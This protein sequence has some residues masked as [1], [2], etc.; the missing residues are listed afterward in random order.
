M[1]KFKSNVANLNHIY[2]S[3]WLI[4]YY[5]AWSY[6]K[7]QS[8]LREYENFRRG[9][10]PFDDQSINHFKDGVFEFWSWATL[11][12]KELAFVAQ[13]IFGICINA[14]LLQASI[15]YQHQLDDKELCNSE[16]ESE[17]EL[18]SDIEELSSDIE[19]QPSNKK[20]CEELKGLKN[21]EDLNE[22]V[23]NFNGFVDEW[24]E[25][26]DQEEKVQRDADADL[27]Y[28]LEVDINDYLLNQT[29]PAMKIEAKWNICEIFID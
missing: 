26:L 25:L 23:E 7:S 24:E 10:F 12:T 2:L 5:E 6:N 20:D 27:N 11:T 1:K 8:I 16:E 19:E 14:A 13:K 28:D 9:A 4:Y 15:T 29:H 17:A 18:S 21:D 3:K 22:Y